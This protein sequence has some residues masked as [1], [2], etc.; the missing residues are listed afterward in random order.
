MQDFALTAYSVEGSADHRL[1]AQAPAGFYARVG[2]R[3]FD[4]GFA[5][6][7]LPVLAPVILFL[8]ILAR[9][10]GGPGF[11]GHTRVG[12]DGRPF[13]CW[14]VR[15]MVADA[16]ARLQAHLD[17]DPA[18]AAEW[19]RDH[20]LANDPRISRLGH[21]LRKTSLDE[22]PQIWNV[23]K[24]EMSFVGPRPIV[25]RELAKYG[26][27]APAY[28]AQ[29]PGITGLWQVSGRNDVSYEERVALDVAYL[30]RR[31]FLADLKI[32]ARTG[33]AVLGATGR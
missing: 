31:S 6:L 4:T 27:S 26:S 20:K 8:W 12:R 32:I 24:G 30:R 10:D 7:L 1:P 11:F 16:E 23:L 28:L 13:K 15:S 29:T 22:L 18:A 14:K 2:K 9:R 3:V 21:V 17:A 25:T 5:L 19:E 33:L